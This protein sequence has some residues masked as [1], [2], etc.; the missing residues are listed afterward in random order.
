MRSM[1]ERAD[2]DY[3]A[4]AR[5]ALAEDVYFPRFDRALPFHFDIF[6]FR[7]PFGRTDLTAAFAIPAEAVAAN[8]VESGHVYP[9]ALSVILYD[10]VQ[11]TVTRQD[12][13]HRIRT[14]RLLGT[15]EFLRPH[16]VQPV[17]SSEHTVY[18][19]VV[20][21]PLVGA[22]TIYAGDTRI[23]DLG[24]QNLL[25]SDLVLAEPDST[26]DWIRGDL[27][28]ALTLPRT[29]RPGRPFQLFYEV[30]NLSAGAGYRTQLRVDP[31]DRGGLFNRVKRLF[32]GGPPHIDLRFED[33]AAPDADGVVQEIRDM[34]TDLPPGRYRMRLTITDSQSGLSAET[35]TT[36]DVIG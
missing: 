13:V 34:G 32:G 20:R 7:T 29:F 15:G 26:G 14:D 25:I 1:L 30:Y 23:R 4:T 16:V 17:I 18:R 2:A 12:T 21:N 35:E 3:R 36:F 27:R 33:T 10:T 22:G 19:V 31:I 8:R 28:L 9:I 24:G 11:G 6:S 5:R